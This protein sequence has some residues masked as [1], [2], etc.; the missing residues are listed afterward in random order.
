M[1]SEPDHS[2]DIKTAM[3]TLGMNQPRLAEELGVD[4]G[5]VSKWINGKANPS[6]P[7]LKLVGRLLADH[8]ASEAAQ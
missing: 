8:A 4:Q 7:V 5:T 6:G 2:Q 3:E 1:Q